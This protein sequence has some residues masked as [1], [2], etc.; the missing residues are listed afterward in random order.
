MTLL[1][2][3]KHQTD[4]NTTMLKSAKWL[5]RGREIRLSGFRLPCVTDKLCDNGKSID[6]SELPFAQSLSWVWLFVSPWTTVA[7]QA[8]LSLGFSRWEYLSGL[9]FPSPMHACIHVKWLQSCLTLCNPMDCSLP[10]SF[11]HGI[12]QT[13]ILEWVTVPFSRG[14]SQPRDWSQV[15]RGERF[16]NNIPRNMNYIYLCSGW[17]GLGS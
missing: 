6:F 3:G 11:I 10:G 17:H 1:P 14:S 13:R 12:F 2:L 5:W 9:P 15:Y 16:R 4:I 7:H 8:P